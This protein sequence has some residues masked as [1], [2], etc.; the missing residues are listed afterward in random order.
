[1]DRLLTLF[2]NIVFFALVAIHISTYFDLEFAATNHLMPAF[3]GVA[4]LVAAIFIIITTRCIES[5]EE[6]FK[7]SSENAPILLGGIFF[8]L[9]PYILMNFFLSIALLEGGNPEVVNGSYFLVQKGTVVREVDYAGYNQLLSYQMRLF[10]GHWVII[11]W[12]SLLCAKLI[13][14]AQ[15]KGA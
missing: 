4:I 13:R 7:L 12:G 2:A 15:N 5:S 9:M 11:G 6:F 3:H 10:T 14:A 1:M 8:P